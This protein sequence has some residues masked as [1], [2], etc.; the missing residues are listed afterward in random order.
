MK[1]W[2]AGLSIAVV[3]GTFVSARLA[4]LLDR[5]VPIRVGLLHSQ[6]GDMAN[7]EKSLIDAEVLALDEIN[8]RGGLLGRRLEWVIADG[9]SNR[10]TFAHEAVRLIETEKV[11]VI[12]GC[13]TSASRKGVKAI[14]ERHNHLLFYSNAYEGL[15]QSPN[16]VYTGAA[17]ES[18]YY[19]SRQMELRQSQGQKVL[20]CRFRSHLVSGRLRNCERLL[21]LAGCRGCWRRIF[22]FGHRERRH[23]DRQDPEDPARCHS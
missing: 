12:F 7:S 21:E 10:F 3:L 18:A 23:L 14:V 11:S 17:P 19:S 4:G 16:I 22:A 8:A 5:A 2:F 15:E 20:P 1:H 13:W 9:R 6:T